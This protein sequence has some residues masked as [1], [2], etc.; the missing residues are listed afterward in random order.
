MDNKGLS[1]SNTIVINETL[2]SSLSKIILG[3]SDAFSTDL[4]LEA[5][6]DASTI[7]ANKNID[8]MVENVNKVR[9]EI[10][11]NTIIDKQKWDGWVKS[12]NNFDKNA[13]KA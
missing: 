2:A 3:V 7:S 9:K 4:T 10:T 12:F 11:N 5:T 8:I 1:S 13:I 6:D